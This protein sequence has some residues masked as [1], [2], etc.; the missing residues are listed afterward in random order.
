MT[1]IP[2]GLRRRYLLSA[3]VGALA[4]GTLAVLV[5]N[6]LGAAV[7]TRWVAVAALAV[8]YTLWALGR[9]L[10]ANHPPVADD[11]T[12]TS[13]DEAGT[14]SAGDG[15]TTVGATAVHG[16]LG[17]ANGVTLARGWLYAWVAGCLLVAPPTGTAWVWAPALAYGGGAALDWVD[18]RVAITVGRRS[19]LGER[20]DLAF[21][22]MGFLVAPVAAVA[23]GA[24]P[25]WYL[26]ISGAR[27]LFKFGCWLRERRGRPVGDLP[28]STVRRP[29]AGLQMTVVAFALVPLTPVAVVWPV[30]TTAMVPSL[31][32]FA[33]DYLAVTGRFGKA[34]AN[35][36][37]DPPSGT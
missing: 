3:V 25:A 15:E 35:E 8:A 27:Y 9:S 33:R 30:A 16:T 28:E 13:A 29:L 26:S 19:V 2:A 17:V 5:G 20:L 12:T 21:D 37:A 18:G 36:T 7:A 10:D 24:L 32:V 23:W 4:T 6:A 31:G 11:V 22:T 14:T 34:N 1:T